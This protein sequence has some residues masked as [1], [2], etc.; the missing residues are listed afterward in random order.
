MDWFGKPVQ[1]ASTVAAKPS[2]RNDEMDGRFPPAMQHFLQERAT[3][4]THFTTEQVVPPIN[5]KIQTP[6]LLQCTGTVRVQDVVGSKLVQLENDV[7]EF[8]VIK[9]VYEGG[10]K[11]WECSLDLIQFLSSSQGSCSGL[12]VAELGC[13]HGLPAIFCSLLGAELIC[14]QDYNAQVIENVTIPNVVVNRVGLG[15]V[16][17]FSGDWRDEELR[18]LMTDK[19]KR[20]F[21]LIL[22]SE[23]IYDIAA[24][25]ALH[26]MFDCLLSPNGRVLVASKRFYFGVGGSTVEFMELVKSKGIFSVEVVQVFEDGLSNIREIIQLSRIN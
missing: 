17:M 13:G 5:G 2:E 4:Q 19:K 12:K 16:E 6:A 24:C 9:G 3:D 26:N 10:L 15:S 21:D 23:T 20:E 1:P 8:D 7:E 18:D 25:D 14:L 22:A 11:V